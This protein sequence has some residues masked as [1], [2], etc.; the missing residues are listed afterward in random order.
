LWPGI[1]ALS[2]E[3]LRSPPDMVRYLVERGIIARQIKK[4]APQ[5]D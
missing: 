4:S 1:E 2:R 5:Q 3:Q